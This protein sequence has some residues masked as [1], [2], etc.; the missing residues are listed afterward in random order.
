MKKKFLKGFSLLAFIAIVS[1]NLT[2]QEV[3][4]GPDPPTDYCWYSDT[5]L[6]STGG[7][8][9]CYDIWPPDCSD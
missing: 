2:S 9:V 5:Y 4:E 1:F 8:V 7:K 3:P 6:C